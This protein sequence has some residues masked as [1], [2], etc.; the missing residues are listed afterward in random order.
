M[1]RKRP[2]SIIL[3]NP[4]RLKRV[5]SKKAVSR[6]DST[7]SHHKVGL[8][9]CSPIAIKTSLSLHTTNSPLSQLFLVPATRTAERRAEPQENLKRMP[10]PHT[11][12]FSN[13]AGILYRCQLRIC[14]TV[15]LERFIVRLPIQWDSATV[16]NQERY[17]NHKNY[18]AQSQQKRLEN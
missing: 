15:H 6:T 11:I 4:I 8:I 1:V 5:G 16:Q 17:R 18:N 10:G 3:F 13:P 14:T 9:F 2:L 12:Y 7:S